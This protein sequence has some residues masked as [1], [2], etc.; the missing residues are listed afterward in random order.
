MST[1][2]DATIEGRVKCRKLAVVAI[3]TLSG[4]D[5]AYCAEHQRRLAPEEIDTWLR[6]APGARPRKLVRGNGR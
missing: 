6:R 5:I 4:L 1:R 2:C 3:R